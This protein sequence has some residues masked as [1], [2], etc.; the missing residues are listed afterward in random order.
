[1]LT[2]AKRLLGNRNPLR[3]AYHA[4]RAFLA[5]FR[6]GFPAR[7]LTVIGVTG[8]DGK[9]TTVGM[10]AHVLHENGIAAG[11][12]ST[13]FFRIRGHIEWNETRLTSPSPFVVQ[14][15]LAKLVKEGCTHAV[16][17]YSSHGL[18][19]HRL[20][21]TFPAVAAITN[22]SQEHLDYHGT[23]RQ[24][25][26]D[27]RRLFTMTRGKGAAVLNREDQT[28]GLFKDLPAAQRF[29]Y[30]NNPPM[31]SSP[32]ATE[33]WLTDIH[34][35]KDACSATL[36]SVREQTTHAIALGIPGL[37]NLENALCALCCLQAVGIPIPKIIESLRTF[38]SAPGRMER[39]DEGQPF[40]VYVDFTVSP[41]AFT[42]TLQALRSTMQPGQ[43]LL[44]LTGS[45]GNR[46]REKR[47]LIGQICSTLAD[48]VVIT[49]DE[50]YSE[51]T[52]Q[53]MA[54]M[55]Q[56]IDATK[57]DAHTIPD[58]RKAIEFILALARHGDI[59]LLCGMGSYPVRQTLEGLIPWNEQE[60]VREMLRSR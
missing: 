14:K 7:K 24:Y 54:D 21:W 11:A 57:T 4:F 45:C 48:A 60:I 25:A 30:G 58:R 55:M 1:V 43:R 18:V 36:H 27:K 59:V 3:L 37:F 20:D 47:K 17:E 44:V 12:V 28:Y 29:T 2:T 19:Q 41:N 5:A 33:Y 34:G 53:I 51:P 35:T 8:T 32:E 16:V 46:M 10:I 50:T 9:T 39:I 40:S 42:K 15:F 49:E 38:H 31:H 56:G 52:E 23:M 6:Y 26:L 13:A 22:L